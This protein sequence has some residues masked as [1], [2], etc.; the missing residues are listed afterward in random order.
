MA[1]D[2]LQPREE[3]LENDPGSARILSFH[4]RDDGVFDDFA[5][6]AILVPLLHMA[7]RSL[8]FGLLVHLS[9]ELC[10][11]AKLVAQLGERLSLPLLV[12]SVEGKHAPVFADEVAVEQSLLSLRLVRSAHWQCCQHVSVLFEVTVGCRV[13]QD[14]ILM[15][16]RG[17][18][19]V[20]LS[21]DE[22]AVFF[23]LLLQLS[24]VLVHQF[25]EE[26]FKLG[27]LL[28][29]LAVS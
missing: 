7:Q 9:V 25:V 18:L 6:H 15:V 27:P 2:V 5:L 10:S 8:H 12:V 4:D 11:Q 17:V 22:L 23:V 13:N 21:L 28:L 14:A 29:H 24:V 26:S 20:S 16:K 1:L 3:G 19:N